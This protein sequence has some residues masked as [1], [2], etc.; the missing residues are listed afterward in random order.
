M[1]AMAQLIGVLGQEPLEFLPG[2]STSCRNPSSLPVG[3]ESFEFW[4]WPNP[5]VFNVRDRD[6]IE[7]RC[8]A[9]S[10]PSIELASEYWI[11][12]TCPVTSGC[13]ADARFELALF[14]GALTASVMSLW[15]LEVIFEPMLR[16]RFSLL[17]TSR[18]MTVPDKPTSLCPIIGLK[19]HV[20]LRHVRCKLMGGDSWQ[21]VC[22]VKG[23]VGACLT[24]SLQAASSLTGVDHKVSGE[25]LDEEPGPHREVSE[26]QTHNSFQLEDNGQRMIE[27]RFGHRLFNSHVT[28]KTRFLQAGE[29][30]NR[31][32]ENVLHYS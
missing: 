2:C 21:P 22:L 28:L 32:V 5:C 27:A 12:R 11:V 16:V 14:S 6:A 17:S 15:S 23:S 8:Q 1:A 7:A 3:R 13:L 26:G 24:H 30:L 29:G 19:H 25:R 9:F 18:R 10:A 20:P 4:R 31:L